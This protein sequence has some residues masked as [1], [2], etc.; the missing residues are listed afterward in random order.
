LKVT[1]IPQGGGGSFLQFGLNQFKLDSFVLEDGQ[2]G[3]QVKLIFTKPGKD[4][5]ITQQTW[6][7]FVNKT[8]DAE[9]IWQF[10]NKLQQ[11][12]NVLAVVDPSEEA[13]DEIFNSLPEFEPDD[14]DSLFACQESLV[15]QVLQKVV[16]QE[17]NVVLHWKGEYL[18]I[19]SYKEN[20]YN[21]TF[22][23]FPTVHTGLKFVKSAPIHVDSE[24]EAETT[25]TAESGW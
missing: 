16:G 6:Y 9:K 12:K 25:T 7:Q 15:S 5:D 4:K 22:G 8:I 13:W 23:L 20:G 14:L 19:P 10:G 3:K 1:D 21:L 18:N 2:Y 24:N 17:M 11:W